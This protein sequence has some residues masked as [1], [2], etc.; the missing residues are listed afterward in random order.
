MNPAVN[1]ISAEIKL[2]VI[3]LLLMRHKILTLV[4]LEGFSPLIHEVKSSLKGWELFRGFYFFVPF[5]EIF[6]IWIFPLK[7]SITVLNKV[8]LVALEALISVSL[9]SSLHW[10]STAFKVEVNKCRALVLK[11]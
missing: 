9:K 4:K 11:K 3:M 6:K 5:D 1:I 10:E 7:I 8:L 2:L